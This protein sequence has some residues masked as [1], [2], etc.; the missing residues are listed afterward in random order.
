MI[1]TQ[2]MLLIVIR[3]EDLALRCFRVLC[4]MESGHC[5]HCQN[6][7]SGKY[8]LHPTIQASPGTVWLQCVGLMF[9]IGISYRKAVDNVSMLERRLIL[10]RIDFVMLNLS[11]KFHDVLWDFG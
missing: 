3:S 5:T 2:S 8:A 4:T 6:L 10:I 9:L 1:V 7:I 11:F